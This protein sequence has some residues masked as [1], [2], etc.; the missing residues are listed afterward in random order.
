MFFYP[1]V[2]AWFCKLDHVRDYFIIYGVVWMKNI[3]I[4]RLLKF[5]FQFK[6]VFTPNRPHQKIHFAHFTP[7][8]KCLLWIFTSDTHF[9]FFCRIFH[10]TNAILF[11]TFSTAKKCEFLLGNAIF[12]MF[13]SRTLYG[14]SFRKIPSL[15]I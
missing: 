9:T 3:F 6:K 4:F 12:F 10:K 7:K 11:N 2:V 13:C 15:S 5:S 14:F 8:K 1:V